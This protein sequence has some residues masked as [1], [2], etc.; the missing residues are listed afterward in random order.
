MIF[1]KLEHSGC[2]IENN[3]KKIICDPVEIE[4]KMPELDNAVA[5]IITHKHGDHFQL[6]AIEKIV[7]TSPEIQ[8]FAPQDLE[9]AEIAG[10]KVEKV[11]AGVG[12]N[13]EDFNLK[14]FGKNHAEIIP[15]KIPC[16]NIGVVVND[17]IVNPGD[18]FDLPDNLP[19]PELLMVPSEAPWIK[20][21]ESMNYIKN[22]KPA[23][24]IPVHNAILSKFGNNI[25]NNWLKMACEETDTKL[26]ALEAGESIEI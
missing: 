24:A 7:T 19:N 22:A 17:K 13:L 5:L 21:Y 4:D 15:G 18:S 16:A 25:N 9:I 8:I 12:W 6:E 11:E 3:G 10:R 23:I 14:F 26:A 1:T 2:V 20:S